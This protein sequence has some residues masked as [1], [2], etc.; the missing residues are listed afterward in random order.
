MKPYILLSNDD[1]Y[2]AAGL[3]YLIETLKPLGHLI[4]VAP[5]GP[6]SGYGCKITTQN[7]FT[8]HPVSH[9]EGID[10]YACSGSPVDCVK[11]AF[12]ILLPRLGIRPSLV[13]SGINHGDNS[14]VNSFYSGTM[15]V[16][17]EGT[18]QGVASIGFSL[19]DMSAN[20]DFSAC[21]P[22][23]V[24]I[25]EKV[26]TEGLPPF[27]CLNVNFPRTDGIYGC[28][29][30]CNPVAAS[31]EKSNAAAAASAGYKGIR[32]CRMARSAWI[33]EVA[34]CHRPGSGSPYYWLTGEVKELEP[35]ATDTDRWALY[36]GYVAVTPQTLDTT[37]YALLKDWKME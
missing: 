25:V 1:G 27:T 13:V 18:L 26:L 11:L 21:G 34:E 3:R 20:A 35:E 4:V 33:N 31:S 6:R 16:V 17:T 28:S 32:V 15:G 19:C 30:D 29:M 10:V 14:S 23:I 5:D 22:Y 12:N 24:R 8:L 9:D 36:H 2:Q 37:A 7:P